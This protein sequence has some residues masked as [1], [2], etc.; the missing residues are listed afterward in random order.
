MRRQS[1]FTLL[2]L[3]IAMTLMG[4][5]L[6]MI[7]GG[8]RLGVRSWDISEQRTARLDEIRLVQGFIR[9]QL[10]QSVA[11]FREDPR[12]GRVMAFVGEPQTIAWVTP[13][14][15]HL[16]LGGLYW[17]Q[18]DVIETAAGEGLRMR[19]RPF[20]PTEEGAGL[21]Q[22][23]ETLLL[24]GVAEVH[25]SY[26]GTDEPGREPQWQERWP[27]IQQRPQLVRLTLTLAEGF[28]PELV[29]ALPEG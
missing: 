18:L 2:E 22:M 1:G 12:A 29:A 6:V 28:W 27:G 23:E 21:G 15:T 5:V 8:L 4:L 26:F 9:R 19:W 17:V 3:V 13:L 25:W 11:V 20:R 14:L 10:G 16:G 24:E 7:Y